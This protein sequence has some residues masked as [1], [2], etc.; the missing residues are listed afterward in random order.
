MLIESLNECKVLIL[1]INNDVTEPI[2]FVGTKIVKSTI[3]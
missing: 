3:L 1:N 2:I